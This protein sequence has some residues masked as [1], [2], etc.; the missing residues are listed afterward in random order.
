MSYTVTKPDQ[1]VTILTDSDYAHG[2]V[3][4]TYDFSIAQI[5]ALAPGTH[6]AMIADVMIRLQQAMSDRVA[7]LLCTKELDEMLKDVLKQEIRSQ[8]RVAVAARLEEI[9]E[10]ITG[11]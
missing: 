5:Q 9:L 8:V 11:D 6:R 7:Q 4:V 1:G 3:R 2:V 10:D